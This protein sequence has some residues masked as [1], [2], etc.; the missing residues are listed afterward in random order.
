MGY[1]EFCNKDRYMAHLEIVCVL[2]PSNQKNQLRDRYFKPLE[3]FYLL[4]FEKAI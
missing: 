3:T 4:T 2:I 1:K